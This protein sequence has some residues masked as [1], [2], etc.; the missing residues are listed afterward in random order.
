M[1]GKFHITDFHYLPHDGKIFTALLV[2]VKK[3]VM[4]SLINGNISQFFN[5]PLN[6]IF[7]SI[8]LIENFP[9]KKKFSSLIA[10]GHFA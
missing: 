8:S 9:S 10:S 3:S 2:P 1:H 5:Q 6:C 4:N 7:Y